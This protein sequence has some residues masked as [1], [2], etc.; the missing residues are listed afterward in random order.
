MTDPTVLPLEIQPVTAD[1]LAPYGKLVTPTEDGVPYGPTDAILELD[2][3]TP[4]FYIMR[5]HH[6]PLL[7]AQITR[8]VD[9]TQCL[10]TTSG[11]PWI[12]VVAP[13]GD[14]RDTTAL[15]DPERIR[16]FLVPGGCIVAQHRGTW[17]AGPYF[18]GETEDFF[19]LELADT[20]ITD[21]HT[22]RLD[23]VFGRIFTLGTGG[24]PNA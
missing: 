7:V 9:V 17:H 16:A 10:A 6:R 8:H 4:R 18:H 23:T 21:H 22:V 19:N 3:G 1:L 14:T 20:N 11:R 12:I 5:L 2:R 15:P 13:P 24:A